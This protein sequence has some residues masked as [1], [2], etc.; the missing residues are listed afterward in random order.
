MVMQDFISCKSV[1]CSTGNQCESFDSSVTCA[2]TFGSGY[3][4]RRFSEYVEA[5]VFGNTLK[6]APAIIQTGNYQSACLIFV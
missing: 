5:L 4:A 2:E 6:S 1:L 3:K